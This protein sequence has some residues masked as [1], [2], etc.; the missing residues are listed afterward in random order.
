MKDVHSLFELL[1]HGQ[2][3][4]VAH[5][6]ECQDGNSIDS[7]ENTTK[8]KLCFKH[9]RYISISWWCFALDLHLRVEDEVFWRANVGG[10]VELG[11]RGVE[12]L[13]DGL[14]QSIFRQGTRELELLDD[15]LDHTTIGLGY[16]SKDFV[17]QFRKPSELL[18]S[19]CLN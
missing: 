7:L 1:V 12:H 4:G 9:N 14:I 18:V 5:E 11:Q 17:L 16:N 19:S 13:G 15:N 10:S 8:S 3:G 6:G 2:D